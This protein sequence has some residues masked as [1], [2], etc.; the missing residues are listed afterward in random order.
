MQ[1]AGFIIATLWIAL[2]VAAQVYFYRR[3]KLFRLFTLNPFRPVQSDA[4]WFSLSRF[5]VGTYEWPYYFTIAID[6]EC[7][8]IFFSG[9]PRLALRPT[10]ASIPLNQLRLLPSVPSFGKRAQVV[11]SSSGLTLML[12]GSSGEFLQVKLSASNP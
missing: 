5:R 10:K 7:L 11:E 3:S 6:T 1:T 8:H 12:F 4:S 9:L 2:L